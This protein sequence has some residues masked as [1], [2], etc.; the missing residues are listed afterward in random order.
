MTA[1]Q[2]ADWAGTSEA[3]IYEHYRH[4]LREIVEVDPLDYDE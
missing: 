4:K 2:V 1:S 3:M